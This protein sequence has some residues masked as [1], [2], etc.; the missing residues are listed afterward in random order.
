MIKYEDRTPQSIQAEYLEYTKD[1][2]LK[3]AKQLDAWMAN[4][5]NGR[6]FVKIA[7][8]AFKERTPPFAVARALF[9]HGADW[10]GHGN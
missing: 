4:E 5:H 10:F 9:C 6:Q 8:E 7:N 1:G 2:V 3:L